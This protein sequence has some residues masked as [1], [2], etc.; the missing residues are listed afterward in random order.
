MQSSRLRAGISSGVFFLI[1]I[2]CYPTLAQTG[3]YTIRGTVISAENGEGLPFA[4][5]FIKNTTYGTA[6][7]T[8]GAFQLTVFSSSVELV[9][10]F[11]GFRTWSSQ[12][13]LTHGVRDLVIE[14]EE[15]KSLLSEVSIA[16]KK[17]EAWEK[18]Y[19]VFKKYFLGTSSN[20]RR[21]EIENAG[22]LDLKEAD[23]VMR[24]L[25]AE[26]LHI[27]NDALGYELDFILSD[28]EASDD[29]Y[30]IRGYTHFKPMQPAEQKENDKWERNR[31]KA[32]LGSPPHFFRAIQN[33]TW[34][35]EGYSM[36][37]I[38]GE[39]VKY[40]TRF[41]DIPKTNIQDIEETQLEIKGKSISFLMNYDYDALEIHYRKSGP[42]VRL[43][44]DV[45]Y[46]VSRLENFSGRITLDDFGMPH[47]S[48]Q[49]LTNGDWSTQRV[50]EMLPMDY[51]ME[52]GSFN[53]EYLR[54]AVDIHLSKDHFYRG[55]TVWFEA[56]MMYSHPEWRD[57]LSQVLHIDLV[58]PSGKILK[59]VSA[60]IFEGVAYGQFALPGR[61]EPGTYYMRAYTEWMRNFDAANTTLF[62]V[63]VLELDQ[64]VAADD[65]PPGPQENSSHLVRMTIDTTWL[66]EDSITLALQILDRY[67]NPAPTNISIAVTDKEQ[68]GFIQ[69]IWNKH[70]ETGFETAFRPQSGAVSYAIEKG[71]NLEGTILDN[72]GKPLKSDW[73]LM[74]PQSGI[75]RPFATDR[76]G[77]FEVDKLYNFGESNFYVLP[78]NDKDRTDFS[79]S[80][81]TLH[82]APPLPAQLPDA[83]I[84]LETQKPP[85]LKLKQLEQLTSS[86][87]RM[88]E[89]VEVREKPF[90]EDANF[91]LRNAVFYGKPDFIIKGE[92]LKNKTGTNDVWEAITG[93]VPG[94]YITR[95][96]PVMD[97][98]TV[99]YNLR[100]RGGGFSFITPKPPMIFVDGIP[101]ADPGNVVNLVSINQIDRIEVITGANAL[102]GGN[103]THGAIF[104]YTTKSTI[105]ESFDNLPGKVNQSFGGE[106]FLIPLQFDERVFR[107]PY[108]VWV[109]SIT[110]DDEGVARF[111]IRLDEDVKEY[112]FVL[113]GSTEE[114]EVIR[115]IKYLKLDQ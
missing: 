47:D 30:N 31:R 112:R 64:A 35:Q 32:Y 78:L 39:D 93:L 19:K 70:L 41:Y 34:K 46:S 18:Q 111:R 98:G 60:F 33:G 102:M 9:C 97:A 17:D 52:G 2:L 103:G 43:Y 49:L 12:L 91:R 24:G 13:Q 72:N 38:R 10:S 104:I 115:D 89:E 56:Y 86:E 75:V 51:Q 61:T 95:L 63:P 23:G 26:P 85:D 114:G 44:E 3:S 107:R 73:I 6:T 76:Q 71:M 108:E 40:A 83:D 74:N 55:D 57:S 59:S 110:T 7:D 45:D 50:S 28:F 87:A 101:S 99:R 16:G 109:P 82:R 1:L 88:L 79:V 25:A 77:K 68:T 65:E 96:D 90:D 29:A 84:S 21:C 94:L 69:S 14:L 20:A 36:Y 5:V 100:V 22:V 37:A 80:L 81:D 53:P 27:R 42:A 48:L 58:A 105:N 15:D 92:A 54:E 67:G 8:L 113:Y 62:P 11:V 106:G 4:S 66:A